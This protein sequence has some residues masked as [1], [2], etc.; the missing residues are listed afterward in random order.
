MVGLTSRIGDLADGLLGGLESVAERTG[1]WLEP[2]L[3]LGVT[4]LSGAGKTVFITALVASLLRRG[5]MGR[6]GPE[7]DGRILAAMLSPQPD[8]AIPRFAY[9]SHVAALTGR[10][11]AWPESTRSVSQLRLSFRY[12]PTGFLTG[13]AGAATLHLDIVDYPGEWLADIPLLDTDY[14]SWARA[15]LALAESPLRRAE[16]ADWRR[17]LAAADPAAEHA[18]PAAEALAAA[19][20]GYLARCRAS[21]LAALSPGRFL[22]PGELAGSPALTFAPLP[23]PARAPRASLYAEMA[24]RFE[25]YKR[26]VARPFFE[27][28]FAALDRQV[29]ML[30]LL[31]ALAAGPRAL[32]DLAGGMEAMLAAFRHG[33]NS[34]LDRILG[35]RRI[36]RLLFVASKADHLHHEQHGAL[37]RLAETMLSEAA[38][39]AAFR[40]AETR[41]M[42]IAAIRATAEQEVTRRG[43]TLR[44]VR[45]RRLDTGREAA[46]YPGALPEDPRP[47]LAAARDPAGTEVDWPDAEFASVPFAPPDWGADPGDGPPHIRLDRALDFLLADKL[48]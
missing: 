2:T 9:E 35:T 47:L 41:A 36:D 19:W 3:R 16:A 40:G 25:A 6:F 38:D 14:E 17:A 43:E 45:G 15:A 31:R 10:P 26:H 29:V 8:P 21:G 37:T 20:A 4:G 42:A 34:W 1:R 5:R 28:H 12:R 27:T 44:L 23:K 39:R 18:E 33:T 11:A 48:E 22:M 30:D 13:L 46:L 24:R 7:A 32:G